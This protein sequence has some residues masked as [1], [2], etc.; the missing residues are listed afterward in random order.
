MPEDESSIPSVAHPIPKGATERC[1]IRRDKTAIS[2]RRISK[3]KNRERAEQDHFKETVAAVR[4]TPSSLRQP[5][6]LQG[7]VMQRWP[8]FVSRGGVRRT[9]ARMPKEAP[10][11]STLDD[12]LAQSD[13]LLTKVTVPES[14]SMAIDDYVRDCV[15]LFRGSSRSKGRKG[16]AQ[17]SAFPDVGYYY[18]VAWRT[19]QSGVGPRRIGRRAIMST[20]KLAGSKITI[21]T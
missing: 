9:K 2:R 19:A 10:P 17:E 6:S 13:E 14:T 1:S 21:P 18:V 4:T 12:A 16:V 15:G 8:S 5:P 11:L 3:I 7:I 20:T